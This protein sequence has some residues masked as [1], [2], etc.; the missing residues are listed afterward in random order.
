LPAT[1]RLVIDIALGL[2][3]EM[4]MRTS[5]NVKCPSDVFISI[6]E[7]YVTIQSTYW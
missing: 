7:Q 5:Y 6:A 1:G 4:I 3:K 2:N